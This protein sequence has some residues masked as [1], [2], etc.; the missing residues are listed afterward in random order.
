MR[1]CFISQD[2]L[3]NVGG[4]ASHVY[5][6]ATALGRAGHDVTLL[7]IRYDPRLPDW[8]RTNF[9]NV[10]RFRVPNVGKL[11]GFSFS[12]QAARFLRQQA[13]Q[14][15]WD[16]IHWHNLLGDSVA[17]WAGHARV[18]IFTNHS[19]QFLRDFKRGA[20]RKLYQMA[21]RPAAAVIAPSL[22]LKEKS[23]FY[24][25]KDSERIFHLPNGV[26]PESFHPIA[27]PERDFRRLTLARR[28]GLK[29]EPVWILC[30]CRLEPVKGVIYLLK[31][32][33]KIL[34][35]SGLQAEFL[36]LGQG[37]QRKALA[38][39]IHENGLK[40]HVHLLGSVPFSEMPAY[41]QASDL[42]VI[43]SLMESTSIA[44]LEALATEL[45]VV[46]SAVGG[47][48]EVVEH[49]RTGVLVPAVDPPAL[50]SSL[51]TLIEDAPLRS[52]YG[53]EG[54]KRVLAGNTWTEIASRTLRI[55]RR[56]AS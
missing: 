49:D 27:E 8:E 23:I 13:R 9:G 3:P 25:G 12:L 53:R 50:A 7:T 38:R 22:E 4:I 42:A 37:S 48:P 6:L 54:R 30:P 2:Y 43:P 39:F 47:L 1:I 15:P 19:S 40:D 33:K 32:A 34:V 20:R 10:R 41:Y 55:Y 26:D 52:R 44:A 21:L 11:R 51:L 28:H 29:R 16:V 31:A 14:G 5:G 45:P 17:A 46:A 56:F 24:L 35:D 36:I 18:K